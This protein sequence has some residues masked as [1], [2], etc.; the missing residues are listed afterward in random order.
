[1]PGALASTALAASEFARTGVIAAN[2][3]LIVSEVLKSMLISKLARFSGAVLFVVSLTVAVVMPVAWSC[4]QSTP[5]G[6][7]AVAGQAVSP[8]QKSDES[9]PLW[10]PSAFENSSGWTW[11]EVPRPY[12]EWGTGIA[13]ADELHDESVSTILEKDGDTLKIYVAFAKCKNEM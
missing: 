11:F 2:T 5:G 8:Q 13:K 4:D 3:E 1:P 6:K 12:A 9:K 10:S 7:T